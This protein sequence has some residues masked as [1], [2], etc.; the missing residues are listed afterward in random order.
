MSESPSPVRLVADGGGSG[1]PTLVLLHGLGVNA[2]AF[3]ALLPVV[4]RHWPGRWVV[5]DLRG[6]GRSPHAPPYAYAV[7][8]ADVANLF[9]QGEAISVI[10]HSMGG[11]VAMLLASGWFGIEVESAIAFGVKL[12]WTGEEVAKLHEISKAAPRLFET[13]EDAVERYL[14]VSG[15]AGVV[16]PRSAIANAG[17]TEQGSRYRLA[18]DPRTNAVA[19]PDVAAIYRASAGRTRLAAGSNDPMVSIEEMRA[20]DPHAVA[21]EGAG[22]NL[23]IERPEALWRVFEALL[24]AGRHG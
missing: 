7:H 9:D 22:H 23:H 20:L 14:R 12:A 5:P 24:P 4:Q 15:M 21:I 8:A 17:V 6:H 3:D 2:R 19:G 1:A 16:D 11:V 18:A 13:R 10:G